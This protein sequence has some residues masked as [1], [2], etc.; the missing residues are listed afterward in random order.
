MNLGPEIWKEIISDN[1]LIEESYQRE[2]ME[3]ESRDEDAPI[4]PRRRQRQQLNEPGKYAKDRKENVLCRMHSYET[5]ILMMTIFPCV[6]Y[7]TNV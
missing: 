6:V 7:A 2:M 1:R 5:Q 4:R 3:K